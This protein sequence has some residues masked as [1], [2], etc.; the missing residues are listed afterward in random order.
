MVIIYLGDVTG[1]LAELACLEHPDAKLITEDNHK[2][3]LPGA[4]YTSIGDL[5]SL[6]TLGT[7]LQQAD[8]IV[9]A[10]PSEQWSDS[11]RG[12]SEMQSWTESYLKFFSFRVPVRNFAISEPKNKTKMLALADSRKIVDTQLW[13][14]GCSISHGI[15]VETDQRYGQLVADQLKLP[16]SFL[17]NGG[18]SIIWSAD[19]ILRSDIKTNDLVVWGLT[20]YP[21]VPWFNNDVLTHV[22]PTSYE[23]DPGLHKKFSF[24]YF[25]S[26]DIQYRSVTAI[27]QVINFCE[28]IGAR[29]LLVSLMDSAEVLTY[30]KDFSN[31]IV[32][33]NIWGSGINELYLDLGTDSVHPGVLTHKFYSDQIIEKISQLDW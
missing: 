14:A 22:V 13:V 30:I 27:M 25:D 1:Y 11:C 6:N 16:V 8:Q 23:K 5:G 19:Q 17:T 2:D 18:T 28:K 32:L 26:E 10:P 3:L 29:L 21:R 31:L 9:Y 7:I 12:V 24:D 33:N 20:S 4:Y 15:G